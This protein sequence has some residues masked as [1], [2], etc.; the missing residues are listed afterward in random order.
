MKWTLL[1]AV[2]LIAMP[3]AQATTIRISAGDDLQRAIDSAADGDTLILAAATFTATSTVWR[4]TLCG[5]CLDPADG[6]NGTVGFLLSGKS[7]TVLGESRT[8]T[9]LVTG[10]G[11]GLLLE[12]GSFVVQNLTV[13]GG[14]RDRDGNA[15]NAAIVVRHATA[16]LEQLDLIDNTERDTSIVVGIGGVIGREGS[17]LI[18]R[19]CRLENNTWDG[20]ALYRGATALVSDCLIKDGRG[21]GI[22]VTWDATCVADRNTVTGYWKGIGSFGTSL[23][24]ARNNFIH[25]NLGWGMVATGESTLEA[26]NNLIRHN[27]NC[28]FA[29]WGTESRGKFINNIVVENGWR[30]EWVCPCVGVWNYGDWGKWIFRHN[31]VFN[32]QD[33]E[34][35]A[36]WDQTG[37]YG[38]LSLDPGLVADSTSF[39]FVTDTVYLFA[40]DS[41]IYNP[42]GTRSHIGLFG[43]PQAWND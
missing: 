8:G 27:G 30:D 20:I 26:S 37:V 24:V 43:G 25:N 31:L 4:D 18:I 1:S 36:I 35:E 7:L 22:G 32:N 28:G 42:D 41:T 6:A 13:T 19:A 40:G 10:A 14:I 29:P 9:R 11:Y 5:N 3:L 17:S 34:Y 39:A 38:N 12:H 15:T 33:G 2:I 23:V 21:A 16:H